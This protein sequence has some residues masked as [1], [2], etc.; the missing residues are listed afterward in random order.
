[1]FFFL[2]YSQERKFCILLFF[3]IIG[4]VREEG[5]INLNYMC[6]VACVCSHQ[7]LLIHDCF[8]FLLYGHMSSI[9]IVIIAEINY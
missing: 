6:V 7:T 8:H 3:L 2:E 9:N 5:K 1:M 4:F